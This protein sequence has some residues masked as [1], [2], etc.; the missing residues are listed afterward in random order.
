[1]VLVDLDGARL[2]GPEAIAAIRA[3]GDLAA[4]PVVGFFS[5]VHAERAAA[6]HAAGATQALPRSA[7]VRD[8][9]RILEDPPRS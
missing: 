5:H 6:A 4:V 9:P 2:P 3:D 1:V 8:L 7:F